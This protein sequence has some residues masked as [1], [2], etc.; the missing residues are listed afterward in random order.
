MKNIN[1]TSFLQK[2][3][4]NVIKYENNITKFLKL[5]RRCCVLVAPIIVLLNE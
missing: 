5:F 4:R 1:L 2:Y 3:I